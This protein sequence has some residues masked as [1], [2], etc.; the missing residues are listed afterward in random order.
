MLEMIYSKELIEV[1]MI[2]RSRLLVGFALELTETPLKDRI[3][4]GRQEPVQSGAVGN[5]DVSRAL[6]YARSGLGC[7][8]RP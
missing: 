4:L 3:Y 6:S 2:L 7:L 1:T 5:D 8:Y